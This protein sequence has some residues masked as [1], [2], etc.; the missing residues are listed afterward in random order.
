MIS[1]ARKFFHSLVICIICL[2][3]LPQNQTEG[4]D[5]E[6][7]IELYEIGNRR[8]GQPT[9]F[10][11]DKAGRLH[12]MWAENDRQGD[13]DRDPPQIYYMVKE[14]DQWS[15]PIDVVSQTVGRVE[16]PRGIVDQYGRIHIVFHGEN[17]LLFYTRSVNLLHESARN[18][19][20]PIALSAGTQVGGSIALD[21]NG[22]LHVVYA[23][24]ADAIYHISSADWGET[25]STTKIAVALTMTNE[26]TAY[27]PL[28][29]ISANGELQLVWSLAPLPEGYPPL[30]AFYARSI[31]GGETWTR[32]RRIAPDDHEMI[33]ILPGPDCDLHV[34][35]IARAGVEGRY[36]RWSENCGRTWSEA[37]FIGEGSGLAGADMALD[38]SG[39]L[40]AVYGGVDLDHMAYVRWDGINWSEPETIL[41]FIHG[42][43]PEIEITNGNRLHIVWIDHTELGSAVWVEKI[44][45]MEGQS[46]APELMNEEYAPIPTTTPTIEQ[47]GANPVELDKMPTSVSG[48]SDIVINQELPLSDTSLGRMML[49]SV[50]PSMVFIVVI[51]VYQSIHRRQ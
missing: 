22:I 33:S 48:G 20:E 9:L 47:I 17:D 32:P 46:L 16:R 11:S 5:W 51:V 8:I 31:D 29:S 49:I 34:I 13:D 6:P 10:L 30:G 14:N 1:S 41:A 27:N 19:K 39:T 28:L 24:A 4:V 12:L 15:E 35:Y 40:H 2:T 42:E 23:A 44:P 37:V 50:L 25:W 18:W 21:Q 43:E 38:S 3:Y 36:H 26:Q 45:Y 7:V